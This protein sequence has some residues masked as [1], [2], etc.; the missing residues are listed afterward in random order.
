M[1]ATVK[2]SFYDHFRTFR[3]Y[4][5]I[6]VVQFVPVYFR[7]RRGIEVAVFHS[8]ASAPVIPETALLGCFT[9][10]FMQYKSPLSGHWACQL[11]VNV[12]LRRYKNM[13]GSA[14]VISYN[15]S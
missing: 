1:L 13:P 8:D 2:K 15:C 5:F 11:H 10:C 9:V 7:V 3:A 6:S 12:V 14:K 4:Y